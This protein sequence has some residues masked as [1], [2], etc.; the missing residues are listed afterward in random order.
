[1]HIPGLT[2]VN[3]TVD[4][5]AH[6]NLPPSQTEVRFSSGELESLNVPATHHVSSSTLPELVIDPSEIALSESKDCMG[7]RMDV[8]TVIVND[9][10][11]VSIT[12]PLD[13]VLA[14]SSDHSSSESEAGGEEDTDEP[15]RY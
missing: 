9:V 15:G 1:M 14:N 3:G 10:V 4:I 11:S 6:Q 5:M 2:L 8:E 7:A 13:V 12:D